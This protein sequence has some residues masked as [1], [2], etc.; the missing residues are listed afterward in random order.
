MSQDQEALSSELFSDPHTPQP[1]PNI[2]DQTQVDKKPI[3]TNNDDNNF[4]ELFGSDD[5]PTLKPENLSPV[6]SPKSEL[7][8]STKDLDLLFQE[9]HPNSLPSSPLPS[10][11]VNSSIVK[12]ENFS[13][14]S[15]QS[16]EEF[17]EIV[18]REELK[19]M[20]VSLDLN[21]KSVLPSQRSIVAKL[22]T[23]L[24]IDPYAFD[25]NN[26]SDLFKSERDDF[27]KNYSSRNLNPDKIMAEWRKHAKT[28][29]ENTIRW[30]KKSPSG[31][32]PLKPVSN[33]Y[34]VK[35]S[36]DSLTLHIADNSP[37][38]VESSTLIS[39]AQ[40]SNPTPSSRSSGHH[41]KDLEQYLAIHHQQEGLLL[42]QSRITENWIVRPAQASKVKDLT[43]SYR[44]VG[45]NGGLHHSEISPPDPSSSSDPVG[46]LPGLAFS[47]PLASESSR[48][49]SNIHKRSFNQ[50][51]AGTKMF[52]PDVDPE[53]AAR[54][55]E[56]AEEAREKAIRRQENSRRR[57]EERVLA[58]LTSKRG[59]S[60]N[61]SEDDYNDD[62]RDSKNY[63]YDDYPANS[64]LSRNNDSSFSKNSKSSRDYSSSRF[65]PK[66][67]KFS[68]HNPHSYTGG[69]SE[70][71]DFVVDDDEDLE[72]GSFDEFDQE[73][74]E[75]QQLRANKHKSSGSA[76]SSRLHSSPSNYRHDRSS[77]NS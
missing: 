9:D 43:A 13:D 44:A 33:S 3:I 49:S 40:S 50:K 56:K 46:L 8:D 54:E 20:E 36:D 4:D 21:P 59:E 60:A 72:V 24:R 29:I 76:K 28:C 25:P 10:A 42:S 2:N 23:G 48:F 65:K 38:I 62:T 55:L 45:P 17:D 1:S 32:D 41:Q 74:L 27:L 6:N 75:E 12:N 77:P 34:L 30:S 47:A 15:Q 31:S 14:N 52:I 7:P 61:Y 71:D 39:R 64:N 73:E 63:D 58:G 5:P 66:Q 37:F 35:W 26:W 53:F 11:K 70:D 67:S 19:V 16:D 18:D 22:P 51:A 69:N 68:S 57:Q